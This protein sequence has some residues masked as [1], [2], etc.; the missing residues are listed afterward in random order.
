MK[1]KNGVAGMVVKL[2][3]AFMG[4]TLGAVYFILNFT[5]APISKDVRE[6]WRKVYEID[7][8]IEGVKTLIANHRSSASNSPSTVD[9]ELDSLEKTIKDTIA[10]KYPSFLQ[11]EVYNDN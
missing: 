7:V 2:C 6:I 10:L 4:A 5:V 11:R 3:L 1:N 9:A 8:K